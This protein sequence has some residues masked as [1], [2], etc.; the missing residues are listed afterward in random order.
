MSSDPAESGAHRSSTHLHCFAKMTEGDRA[1]KRRE[2]QRPW[3]LRPVRER[4]ACGG[5]AERLGFL[6]SAILRGIRPRCS[7]LNEGTRRD[8]HAIAIHDQ[9]SILR[10]NASDVLWEGWP[11]RDL[12]YVTDAVRRYRIPWKWTL[13]SDSLHSHFSCF[14]ISTMDLKSPFTP[15]G[16]ERDFDLTLASAVCQTRSKLPR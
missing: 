2:W 7:T 9:S 15:A 12:L 5:I 14:S 3:V 1:E 6:L 10:N 11:W 16:P 4:C 13:L 8:S